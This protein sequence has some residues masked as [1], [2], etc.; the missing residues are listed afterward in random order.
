MEFAWEQIGIFLRAIAV[1]AGIMACYDVFRMLRTAFRTPDGV[2]FLEDILFFAA[3][4]MATWFYLLESCR[5]E[6]RGFV[7]VGEAL[8]GLLYFLTLGSLVMKIARP[9]IHFIQ[10][11]LEAVLFRPARWLWRTAVRVLNRLAGGLKG[12]AGWIFHLLR[13]DKLWKL[14][15]KREKKQKN[16]KTHLPEGHKLLYNLYVAGFFRLFSGIKSRLGISTQEVKQNEQT[17]ELPQL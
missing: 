15:K 17:P 13:L 12:A 3:A 4:G 9:V 6:L 14:L 7:M 8:G 16:S 2:V 11:V 10:R 5:G 1:G